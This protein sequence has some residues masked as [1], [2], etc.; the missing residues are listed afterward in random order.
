MVSLVD[1]TIDAQMCT[2]Y[3]SN[4]GPDAALKGGFDGGLNA[5]LE[6]LPY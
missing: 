5:G 6:S 2:K 4:G 1:A 3:S